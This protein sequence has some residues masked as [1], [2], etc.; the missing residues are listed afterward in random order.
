MTSSQ[1]SETSLI[2]GQ[3]GT[4]EGSAFSTRHVRPCLSRIAFSRK[5]LPVI[6]S[7]SDV[8]PLIT[9]FWGQ[10]NYKILTQAIARRSGVGPNRHAH[11]TLGRRG[12]GAARDQVVANRRRLVRRGSRNGWPAARFD[13]RCRL[14]ARASEYAAR[15]GSTRRSLRRVPSARP[16]GPT[17]AEASRMFLGRRA[18]GRDRPSADPRRR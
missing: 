7:R 10:N 3:L 4:N 9:N 13:R 6:P 5:L 2:N 14:A 12:S 16:A 18:S 11:P 17:R 15:R 8:L 1:S